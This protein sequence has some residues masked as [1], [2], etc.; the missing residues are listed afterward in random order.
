MTA[1]VITSP[2]S[3]GEKTVTCPNCG[4]VNAENS[5]FCTNCGQIMK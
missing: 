5:K 3:E 2:A 4:S 1:A